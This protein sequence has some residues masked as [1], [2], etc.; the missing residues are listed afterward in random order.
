V[1]CWLTVDR[2]I[3]VA[4]R[5]G[6]THDQIARGLAAADPP[7]M[8]FERID[9][10]P[11]RFFNDAYNASPESTRAALDTF[12]AL[13]EPDARRILVL[14]DMLELGDHEVAAHRE[15]GRRIKD[16]RLP[17]L[18]VVVGAAA[19]HIADV[20]EPDLGSSHILM[21]SE[22]SE[23]NARKV[24]DRLRP[25]DRVLLKGS[26]AIGL[27]RL[28]EAARRPASRHAGATP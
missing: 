19:L 5:L 21:L 9:A 14:G 24:L 26:R 1:M 25:G 12:D 28:V 10:G 11:I 23:A 7:P 18:L 15:V 27:E 20:V 16:G 8:R 17:D 3:A 6:L 13:V 4:R 22:M 2:A